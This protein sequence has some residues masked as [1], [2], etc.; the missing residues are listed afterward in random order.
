MIKHRINTYFSIAFILLV[1]LVSGCSASVGGSSGSSS[2]SSGEN[3]PSDNSVAAPDDENPAVSQKYL[4]GIT[5]NKLPLQVNYD[6]SVGDAFDPNG[7]AVSQVYS[8]GSSASCSGYELFIYG[9]DGNKINLP[10]GVGLKQFGLIGN[11]EVSVGYTQGDKNFTTHFTIYLYEGNGGEDPYENQITSGISSIS[12]S[13]LPTKTVYAKGEKLK[14]YGIELLALK[15]GYWLEFDQEYSVEICNDGNGRYYKLE[16]ALDAGQNTVTIIYTRDDGIALST[17]FAVMVV[18]DISEYKY[19]INSGTV[20]IG[21]FKGMPEFNPEYDAEIDAPYTMV[22]SKPSDFE[23]ELLEGSQTDI[24]ITKIK[25]E[26]FDV[27][28]E[29]TIPAKI[30]GLNVKKISISMFFKQNNENKIDDYNA[31]TQIRTLT[32]EEGVEGISCLNNVESMYSNYHWWYILH[33]KVPYLKKLTLPKGF[34]LEIQDRFSDIYFQSFYVDL[35]CYGLE[36][37]TLPS[38]L[39]EINFEISMTRL[40]KLIIPASVKRITKNY[41]FSNNYYLTDVQ[42]K[43]KTNIEAHSIFS[44]CSHLEELTFTGD[45]INTDDDQFGCGYDTP[46]VPIKKLTFLGK[47]C[48]CINS[49][50]L[51]EVVMPY[52]SLDGCNFKGCKNLKT[53]TLTDEYTLSKLEIKDSAF[54]GCSSLTAS[55]TFP[56]VRLSIGKRAFYGCYSLRNITFPA[57]V[58]I[59]TGNYGYD[60]VI[61]THAFTGTALS[62]MTFKSGMSYALEKNAFSKLSSVAFEENT[63]VGGLV[64]GSPGFAADC[65]FSSI[66]IPSGAIVDI[67]LINLGSLKTISVSEGGSFGGRIINC[68]GLTS[69]QTDSNSI[70]DPYQVS[71]V[72]LAEI[73]IRGTFDRGNIVEPDYIIG[74]CPNLTKVTFDGCSVGKVFNNQESCNV[75]LKGEC[76]LDSYAF[77]DQPYLTFDASEA[78]ELTVLNYAFYNCKG[79]SKLECPNARLVVGGYEISVKGDYAFAECTNL[80]SVSCKTLQLNFGYAPG[81]FYNCESLHSISQSSNGGNL[82]KSSGAEITFYPECFYNCK[83]LESIPLFANVTDSD[84]FFSSSKV[85]DEKT[86]RGGSGYMGHF[87]NC[88]KL[89]SLFNSKNL[90]QNN[91][92]KALIFEGMYT[93]TS[94]TLDQHFISIRK[95]GV[96]NLTIPHSVYKYIPADFANGNT[97]LQ[98]VSLDCDI[99]ARAFK[100]C[101]ALTTVTLGDTTFHSVCSDS[102]AN[103][104]SLTKIIV[105]QVY[106][107][108]YKNSPCWQTYKN[109]ICTQ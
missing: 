12:V 43:G 22:Y 20:S 63:K 96:K 59:P 86:D 10:K 46:L 106:Y 21:G 61:G 15:D 23:Y 2:S 1:L 79:L 102:F 75:V 42:F 55:F 29:V 74:D 58:A 41:V 52:N 104:S 57:S 19:G 36:E 67:D 64:G 91:L 81:L 92:Y 17:T 103:C 94:G 30:N 33:Y 28:T 87:T 73:Y 77:Y 51:E 88:T 70:F 47:G 54:E 8:D 18:V 24:I 89:F 5:V 50:T 97:S 93:A 101:T 14:L 44:R 9:N 37:L 90:L 98:S 82:A 108:Q 107:S 80:R 48:C 13:K 40:K 31:V 109:L 4:T 6:L 16:D 53:L 26:R 99:E 45:L 105:P 68:S 76:W 11:V 3:N 69:I 34:S 71:G 78:T 85:V 100:G 39:E 27:I 56:S 25:P 35:R 65:T 32:I 62:K 95:T 83:V 38:D 60:F 84:L 72:G 66:S 49:E 7:I